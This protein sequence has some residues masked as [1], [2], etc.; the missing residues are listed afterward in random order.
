[1]TICG[2][3]PVRY[4]G[5]YR[6]LQSDTP[7]LRDIPVRLGI[8]VPALLARGIPPLYLVQFF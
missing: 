5:L 8:Y 4:V 6:L 7:S 1:M 3:L 2:M